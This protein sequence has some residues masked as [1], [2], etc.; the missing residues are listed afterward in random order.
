MTHRALSWIPLC[1]ALLFGGSALAQGLAEV[2]RTFLEQAAQNSHAE[3]S[4]GRLALTKTRDPKV[5]DYAQ[6]MVDEHTRAGEELRTL[7][8]ARQHEVPTEPSMAQKGKEMIIATLIDDSSFDRRY[9][10][11]MGVEAPQ[12]A[13]PLYEKTARESRDPEVK[14]FASKQL[15]ALRQ[16]L[17]TAKG[18]QT[19]ADRR[20]TN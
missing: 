3:V 2:D 18:L 12:T 13:I 16:Q 11:Q 19:P 10:A 20:A 8:A 4:A 6:R 15:P 14:A 9:L 1:T 5:R 7:A 17:Q